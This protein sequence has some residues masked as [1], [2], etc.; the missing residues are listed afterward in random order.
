MTISTAIIGAGFAG[1]Y[2]IKRIRDAG[3]SV[4]AFEAGDGI[5]GTWYWNHYPGAQV[6]LECWDYSYSFS[7]ELQ[8]EW[9]WSHRYPSAREL[10]AYLEHVADRFDLRKQI[11]FN[12][13]V[14]SAEFI[15]AE[16][17]WLEARLREN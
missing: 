14:D 15:E 11:Q 1:L 17:L 9:E 16:N 13:R 8:D 4:Q 10:M 2:A 3:F 6:D 7:P 5:G 12:T